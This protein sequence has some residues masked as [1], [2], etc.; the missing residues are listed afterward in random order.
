M[1]DPNIQPVGYYGLIN[2]LQHDDHRLGKLL[3]QR[4]TKGFDDTET[5]SL[6]STIARFVLPRLERFMEI[7]IAYPMG[8]SEE[9]WDNKLVIMINGF[10]LVVNQDDMDDEY[11][12]EQQQTIKDGMELFSKHFF[13]LWW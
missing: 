7:G 8:M 2:E 3:E 5:W 12:E 13:D 4:A 11:S 9:E 10:R 1:K 6:Y